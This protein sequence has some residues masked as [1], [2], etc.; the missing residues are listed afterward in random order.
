MTTCGAAPDWGGISS[1]MGSRRP[2]K[3]EEE[4]ATLGVS[5]LSI[6]GNSGRCWA[7]LQLL[8]WGHLFPRLSCLMLP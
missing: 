6:P 3:E 7:L 5:Q 1:G 2:C 8:A 4:E